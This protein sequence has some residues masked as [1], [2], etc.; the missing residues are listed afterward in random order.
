MGAQER[1]VYMS[2][3]KPQPIEEFVQQV[4]EALKQI[5]QIQQALEE[6]PDRDDL[7]HV[8]SEVLFKIEEG[9]DDV[10]RLQDEVAEVKDKVDDLQSEDR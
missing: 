9:H 3:H 10:R 6:K 4:Q 5:P 7:E 1:E 2:T 8:S